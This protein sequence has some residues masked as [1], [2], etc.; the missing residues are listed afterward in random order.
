M[1]N[2]FKIFLV[3]ILIGYKSYGQTNDFNWTESI[4]Y[5]LNNNKIFQSKTYFDDTSKPL[6]SLTKDFVTNFVW[7]SETVYDGFGRAFKQ[8]FPAPSTLEFD[9]EDFLSNPT[10]FL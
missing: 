3:T 2:I 4:S 7:G 9:K 5:D 8:S 1:K 6:V 10:I